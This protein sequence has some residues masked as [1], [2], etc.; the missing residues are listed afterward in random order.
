MTQL[1][2]PPPPDRSHP[3]ERGIRG[4]KTEFGWLH[5]LPQGALAESETGGAKGKGK[6]KAKGRQAATPA[7]RAAVAAA[8]EDMKAQP[9]KKKPRVGQTEEPRESSTRKHQGRPLAEWR[10]SKVV[11]PGWP[12]ARIPVKDRGENGEEEA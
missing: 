4:L 1:T 6:G 11:V 9:K 10:Q 7:L 12:N 2:Q 5:A 8:E 3:S